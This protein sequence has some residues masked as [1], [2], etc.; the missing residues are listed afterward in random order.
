VE[1][2]E[3]TP[4]ERIIT[5][6]MLAALNMAR[7]RQA[8]G[9]T[10]EQLGA[11]LGGW[12]K[13][14]VSAAERSWDGHRVRQF[15]ADLLCDLASVFRIPV[16]A[17]FLPPEDDGRTARYAIKGDDGPV[18]MDEYFRV[19]L[20]DIDDWEADTAAG[21][22][23]K[24]AV[25]TAIARYYDSEARAE[26]GAAVADVATEE[27]IAAALERAR[28]TRELTAVTLDR[29][30]AENAVLQDALE[31]ALAARKEKQ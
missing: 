18:P 24:Q 8:M 30:L 7:W 1:H 20:P 31:R 2:T 27:Q 6:N 3:S 25:I 19:V 21:A 4:P 26:V 9:W 13:N 17:F 14:A 29:L 23:Y 15:D 22:A 11:E 12:T 16:P 28:E 10:Q 5:P